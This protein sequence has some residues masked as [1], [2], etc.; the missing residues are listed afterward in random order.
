VPDELA[1]RA[2]T[3]EVHRDLENRLLAAINHAK[4]RPT[5]REEDRPPIDLY[6]EE[7]LYAFY[8]ARKF[9]PIFVL[10]GVLEARGEALLEVLQRCDQY[11]MQA[12]DYRVDELLMRRE[13]LDRL[14]GKL[15]TS[16]GIA[17]TPREI[18]ALALTLSLE[19][20]DLS[21]PGASAVVTD[22]LLDAG[23]SNP[24]LRVHGAF[25]LFKQN[26]ST[27]GAVMAELEL[28]LVDS[29]LLYLRDLKHGNLD[30][31]S[32][33]ERGKYGDEVHPK[34]HSEIVLNRLRATLDE[35]SN[36]QTAE[37]VRVILDALLPKH[38]QF[39][40]LLEVRE[41][42]R[43]IAETGG[44]N[45][46]IP[47]TLNRGGRA[48]KVT[49]LKKRLATEGFYE[50]PI[51]DLYDAALADAIALYQE[52]H[53]M[54]ITG[55][56]SPE[57]WRSLNISA[58]Q[59]LR[60][61]EVNIRRWLYTRYQ[62]RDTYIF[63]NIADFHGELWKNGERK[64]R[65]KVVVGNT[66]RRCDPKTQRWDYLNASPTLHSQIESLTFNPYWTVPGRIHRDEFTPIVSADPQYFDRNRFEF[67][68]TREGITVL[69]QLPGS[70]NALGQVKFSFPNK[71]NV[72]M[73]DTP[74]TQFFEYPVRA[75]SHGCIRV[76]EPMQL[77]EMLLEAEGKWDD[78]TIRKYLK[79]RGETQVPLDNPIDVFIEY[80]TVRVDEFGRA[81]FLADIYKYVRDV[82][83]PP[84]AHE[85][86]CDPATQ[87]LSAAGVPLGA[88]Y[89]P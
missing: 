64:H 78:K 76:D 83:K 87:G 2:A 32:P 60:E 62:P 80:Y 74:K 49:A 41:R 6:F 23:E 29:V 22:R 19:S 28:K 15:D 13:R 47:G 43:G 51:D 21:Q 9:E 14:G 8:E 48:P 39:A 5:I 85:L 12:E 10:D 27:R 33:Q 1:R 72:Y 58:E 63:V 46:V 44:W 45:E 73:H 66:Q 59:R 61:I 36:T 82:I 16:T 4:T 79:E 17:L 7:T 86:R 71:F 20:F 38:P 69:R 24:I 37:E 56:P 77:A 88:D 89:G 25:E 57:F 67:H 34:Y 42:Y 70:E 40:S 52:T 84:L 11:A 65:F 50:G 31:L 30:L 68:T 18:R 55:D 35:L 81:H 3:T 54:A 26:A 53:Q 75:F